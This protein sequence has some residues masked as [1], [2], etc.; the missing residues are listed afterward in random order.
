MCLAIKTTF[1]QWPEGN[2]ISKGNFTIEFVF[3]WYEML[4]HFLC[5]YGLQ[6]YL[7]RKIM[8]LNIWTWEFVGISQKK[9]TKKQKFNDIFRYD[10]IED[11]MEA[12]IQIYLH[13]LKCIQ[14]KREWTIFIHPVIPVLDLTRPIVMQFNRILATRL[15]AEPSLHWLNFVNELLTEDE[16]QLKEEFQFDNTHLHPSY[17]TLLTEAM[18]Q[19]SEFLWFENMLN[20]QC[21]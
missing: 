9:L 21:S 16:G 1:R 20:W 19:L 13:V 6:M 7:Y 12:V 2:L 10:R 18:G 17:I 8:F 11:G 3:I 5:E 14:E 15:L 4:C